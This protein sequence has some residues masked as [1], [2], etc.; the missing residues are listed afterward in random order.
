MATTARP[1]AALYFMPELGV[2]PEP[3]WLV[4]AVAARRAWTT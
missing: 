4:Y 3:L 1:R 2:P